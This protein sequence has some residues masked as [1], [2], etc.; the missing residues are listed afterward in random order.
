LIAECRSCGSGR[1]T[2][3]LDLGEMPIVNHFD[4]SGDTTLYPLR[5]V[6][7]EECKLV[8]TDIAIERSLVFGDDYPYL[9]SL[10]KSLLSHA[11]KTYAHLLETY[12]CDVN[13]FVV[14]IACNDG[15]LLRHFQKNAIPCLGVEPSKLAAEQAK[16]LHIPV[17]QEYFGQTVASDIVSCH[18]RANLV[19]AN[20]VL[21]HLKEL[22]D[23]LAG[24]ALLL[25]R[26]GSFVFEVQYLGDLLHQRAFDMF[27]H[28]HH[29]YYSLTAI[30]N[31]LRNVRLKGI[32]VEAL[33]TQGGS[34][35]VH[36]VH[37]SDGTESSVAY[38]QLLK[39]E[40]GNGVLSA[41]SLRQ[42]QSHV[43]K[44][45]NALRQRLKTIVKNGGRI[46]AYGAAA[47]GVIL[48]NSCRI[49][50]YLDYVID[51]NPHKQGCFLPGTR[52]EVV[53]EEHL[54]KQRPTHILILAWNIAGEIIRQLDDDEL[55]Y[56]LPF[57]DLSIPGN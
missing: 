15:Y 46:A 42:L 32:H 45:K 38:R 26:N 47:K 36:A 1:L 6:L 48:V 10:S 44:V 20:N 57:S 24:V 3:G 51:R 27:Y 14:E 8:Q 22:K 40:T 53:S 2:P 30:D 17:L 28:E 31:L 56:L 4:K 19:I 41:D 12:P 50:D 29:S 43:E 54:H 13:S 25:D 5:L 39:R 33:S 49:C 52:L 34:L 37:E 7:C 16:A 55:V 23:F 18:D 35:R 9:S 11:E 21:A